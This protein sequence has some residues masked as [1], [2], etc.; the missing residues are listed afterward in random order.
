M[1]RGGTRDGAGRKA[2]TL[3]KRTQEVAR[4]VAEEGITPLEYLVNVMNDENAKESLRIDAAKAAAPYMHPRLNAT[5]MDV[6]ANVSFK[7][8]SEFG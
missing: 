1:G 8:V 4:R 2:G 5:T 7:V 6:N 3:N